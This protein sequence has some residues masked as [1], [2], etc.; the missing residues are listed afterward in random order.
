[1]RLKRWS[2]I[3]LVLFILGIL[4]FLSAGLKRTKQAGVAATAGGTGD[5]IFPALISNLAGCL[6]FPWAI[7]T[8]G[9]ISFVFCALSVA[10]L[11]ARAPLLNPVQ[12]GKVDIRSLSELRFSLLTAAIVLVNFALLI[13][14]TY[15]PSYAQSRSVGTTYRL[16]WMQHLSWADC[17]WILCWPTWTFQCD[18]YYNIR[19][20]SDHFRSLASI[21][22]Q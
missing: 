10:L 12:R 20:F 6:G 7:R 3:F 9:F 11:R 19:L 18:D 22:V 4:C 14:L 5:I 17:P 21:P 2:P 16:S 8:V 1:M 15:L 13:P